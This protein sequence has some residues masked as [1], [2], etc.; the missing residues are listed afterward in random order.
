[1]RLAAA[2]LALMAVPLAAQQ[3][4][5]V[6]QDAPAWL[7]ISYE[8]Q[9][10]QDDGACAPQV[11]VET[12]VQGSPAERAGLRAGDVILALEG[13]APA[14]RLQSVAGRLTPGD[15]VHLR[16]RRDERQMDII[17]VAD[18]RPDR[19]VTLFVDPAPGLRAT[20]AP[21]VAVQGERLVARNLD[22]DWSPVRTRGYWLARDGQT[23]YRSLTGRARSD[24]DRNVVRLLAC[25]D[26]ARTSSS[27]WTEAS[28]RVNL[29]RLQERADSIRVMITRRAMERDRDVNIVTAPARD[30]GGSAVMFTGPEGTY[31][32][33][34]EDHMAVGLRGVAGAE[35]T[36]LEP[37]LAEYFRNTDRGLL[38]LRI[39]PGTPADRAGLRP[40]DVVTAAGG[41]RMESVAELRRILALPE[42]GE[43]PLRV[44]RKGRTLDLTLPRR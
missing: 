7:G 41:R 19:P 22:I 42:A 14:D 11:V 29:E 3:A 36:E 15:S 24:L 39:A 8:L 23:E 1:M 28:V 18:R 43:V 26:S 10:V 9:W 34:V 32:F 25:A 37:E 6:R 17:A 12:V 21:V 5:Y 33:R 35:L 20:T 2:A 27:T 13:D 31:T 4:V 44:V 30:T 40:G 16:V 38:V